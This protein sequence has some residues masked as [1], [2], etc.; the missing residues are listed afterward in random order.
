MA[1]RQVNTE[2]PAGE[3]PDRLHSMAIHLLRRL[4]TSDAASGLSAPKLSAL[5]VLVFGGPRSLGELAAAEQIRPPSMTRLVQELQKLGLVNSAPSRDDR[6][7]VVIRATAKG[8]RLL[9]EGRS[10][11]VQSLTAML[12][13]LSSSERSTVERA[14]AILEGMLSVK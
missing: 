5:S 8:E 13:A 6:R 7:A 2:E 12:A 9:Q 3:L 1:K 10:R 4:R 11:R 14:V